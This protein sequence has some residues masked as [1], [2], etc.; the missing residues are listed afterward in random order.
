MSRFAELGAA[1]AL[2]LALSAAPALAREPD[3]PV[4]GQTPDAE[5]VAL[6]PVEDLNLKKD[7]IPPALLAAAADP[8]ASAGLRKC[9]DIA[10]AIAPLDAALGPDMD[11]A[12]VAGERVSAGA[13]AKSVVA[14][15]IPFRGVI[16]ELTGAADHQ[17]EFQAAIYAGAVRRGFLKGLGQQMK[18]AYPARP[19]FTRV[20][21]PG[22]NGENGSASAEP[23]S[24]VSEPVVQGKPASSKR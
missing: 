15:F 5:D 10:A 24:F 17:R 14:S 22:G 20:A 6:T 8:Y 7:A 4:L 11:V 13:V 23:A 12:D 19:A 16:R 1:A 21:A 9:A 3:Q 2:A 18:C